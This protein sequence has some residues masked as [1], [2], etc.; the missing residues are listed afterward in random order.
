MHPL[1]DLKYDDAI[2]ATVVQC[3]LGDDAER[4]S[5]DEARRVAAERGSHLVQQFDSDDG[6][7][8]CELAPLA[9]PPRWE[10]G[11]TGPAPFD[12][13]L[14][15]VSSRGCRDYLMGRAGT[16]TGRISAWCP[17]AAPEYRSYNV[18]FRDL[19]EMSEA[20]RYFVAGLLAGVVPAAPIE[21]GPS[22]EAADQADRSAWYA[23][24]YLFRTRSGAW[25]EHWRVCT[26]CGAVLLPSNLD[27]RCSRHSDEG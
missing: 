26:E 11:E 1:R 21:S 9:I 24:Q 10:E 15:F 3:G 20:S 22:D 14:W 12:D 2:T 8:Y 17:H 23:A 6:T 18:S 7:A 19:A 25:T 16:Y 13:M 5:L 4:M 27:D